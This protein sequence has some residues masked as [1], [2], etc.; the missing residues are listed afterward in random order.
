[1][2]SSSVTTDLLFRHNS[3]KE[4]LP[5]GFKDCSLGCPS[6]CTSTCEIAG[7]RLVAAGTSLLTG[8]ETG[9]VDFSLVGRLFRILDLGK[10][11]L[12]I[13]ETTGFKWTGVGA[14]GN[15]FFEFL[16]TLISA[17]VVA[18]KVEHSSSVLGAVCADAMSGWL[19]VCER[20]VGLQGLL[21]SVIDA[22]DC[23]R[24]PDLAELASV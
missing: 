17:K 24:F 14:V 15:N 21:V 3:T 13:K 16:L 20:L 12:F 6:T 8:F 23:F 7:E 1:M 10:C 22:G 5:F 4:P 19:A 18:D 11:C 9:L 2:N